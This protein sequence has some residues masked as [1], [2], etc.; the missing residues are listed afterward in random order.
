LAEFTHGKINS[1]RHRFLFE[2]A[3]KQIEKLGTFVGK[4]GKVVLV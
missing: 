1:V 2:A 4:S 3:G